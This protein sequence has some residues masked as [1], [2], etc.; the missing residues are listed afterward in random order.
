MISFKGLWDKGIELLPVIDT[1]GADFKMESLLI[2]HVLE[3]S[4]V[5]DI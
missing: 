5:L 3:S 4:D 2:F 1:W